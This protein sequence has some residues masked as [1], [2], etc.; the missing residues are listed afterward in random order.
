MMRLVNADTSGGLQYYWTCADQ[1]L[2][3]LRDTGDVYN[4]VSQAARKPCIFIPPKY[5]Y[6][7]DKQTQVFI[8][9]FYISIY[10]YTIYVNIISSNIL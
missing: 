6:R 8:I 9:Y 7:L 10:R 4:S 5:A 3:Y 2:C 1:D